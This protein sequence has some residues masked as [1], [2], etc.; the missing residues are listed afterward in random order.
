MLLDTI[1]RPIVGGSPILFMITTSTEISGLFRLM[2]QNP[3]LTYQGI[4]I[5]MVG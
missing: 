2:D 1:G 4:Q 3:P 5:Q